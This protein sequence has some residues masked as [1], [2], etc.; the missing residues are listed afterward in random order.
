MIKIGSVIAIE[1]MAQNKKSSRVLV[2]EVVNCHCDMIEVFCGESD[3]SFWISPR[4]YAGQ[5]YGINCLKIDD[6]N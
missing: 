1:I 2:G 4:E 3:L 6:L 5:V